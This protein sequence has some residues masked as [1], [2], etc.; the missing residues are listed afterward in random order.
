MR[1]LSFSDL[2]NDVE[3]FMLLMESN[4]DLYIGAGDLVSGN[5]D[6][7]NTML[8]EVGNKPFLMV[9]G[10]N[11]LPSWIPAHYNL[12]GKMVEMEG[13]RF[14]GL[15]GSPITP[16]ETIFEWEEDYAFK[17]LEEMGYVDVL[18]SHTPP[19]GSK[20]SLTRMGKDIGSEAVRWYVDEFRPRVVIAG[21]VHE[22]AGME[23]RMGRT[24][25]FNPGRIGAILS[26]NP[27]GSSHISWL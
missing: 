1:V 8:R 17:V 2:H 13:I 23:D 25:M 26:I 6:L 27:D 5:R 21:H 24:L 22:R 7:L 16:F 10:N 4:A 12:H 9:P 20:L 15:G 3:R 19:W 18:V 14:G 11:E